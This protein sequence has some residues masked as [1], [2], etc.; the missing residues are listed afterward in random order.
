VAQAEHPADLAE[1]A[2]DVTAPLLV[3][4][5]S[6]RMIWRLEPA[7]RPDQEASDRLAL[8]MRQDLDVSQ[9]RGVVDRDVDELP[10][11]PL[12]LAAPVAGAAVPDAPEAGELLGIEVDELTGACA[13]VAPRRRAR[14]ERGQP[15]ETQP[16]AMAGDGCS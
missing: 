13:I 8:L 16:P 5:R 9:A 1:E 10:A 7:Q 4:T 6:T 14:F 11:I 2:R 3:I 15:T 12:T